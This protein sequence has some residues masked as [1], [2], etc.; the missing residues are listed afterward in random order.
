VLNLEKP[1]KHKDL[2]KVEPRDWK[3]P[4][5]NR[6]NELQRLM[7]QMVSE[8]AE[9]TLQEEEDL[10]YFIQHYYHRHFGKH[11]K[12]HHKKKK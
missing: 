1:R 11:K 4:Q 5:P 9:V 6:P 12:M 10:L 3:S 2:P 7:A 8:L